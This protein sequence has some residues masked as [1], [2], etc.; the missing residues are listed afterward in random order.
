MSYILSEESRDLLQDVRN[1]C[2]NELKEQVKEY[3]VSGEWPRE[4]YEKAIEMQLHMLDVPEEYGGLGLDRITCAALIEQIAIADAG[5]AVTLSGNGLALKPV[6]ISGNDEQKAKCC[7]II[8]NGGFGCFALTEPNAGSD[9][10]GGKTTAVRDGNDYILNG[11]KCFITSAE[12]ADFFVVT[13]TTNKELGGTKGMSAFLV[14]K[15][16]PGLSV[17]NHENKM[18]VRTSI[19]SDVVLDDVRVPAENMIGAENTGFITAMKTLDLAR[20]NC[21]VVATGVA[22]RCIDEAVEYGKQRKQFGKP[23]LANQGLAFKVADMRIRTEAARGLI[24]QALNTA[25]AGLP[26]SDLGSCAKAFA[27]DAVQQNAIDA[28]QILGGYGYSRE[29]PVEKLYRDAKI[30][31]IFEGTN[32]IQKIVIARSNIGKM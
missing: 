30:F 16:T 28:V 29:Y 22:Q 11:R 31:S 21:A 24:A 6:L 25:D 10:A 27:G 20:I 3:D 4:L 2:Q 7:D 14:Y 17:G 15:G 5:M 18:G 9:P 8:T 12:V 19:T 23:I 1:F 26:F 13:A 32:E